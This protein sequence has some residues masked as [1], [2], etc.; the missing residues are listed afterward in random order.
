MERGG[1]GGKCYF[2]VVLQLGNGGLGI[3]LGGVK[4]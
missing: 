3:G 2:V 4:E 1:E